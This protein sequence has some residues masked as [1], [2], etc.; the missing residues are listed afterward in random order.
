MVASL[1]GGHIIDSLGSKIDDLWMLLEKAEI[2]NRTENDTSASVVSNDTD[3]IR[4]TRALRKSAIE[5]ID[6]TLPERAPPKYSQNAPDSQRNIPSSSNVSSTT[7]YYQEDADSDDEL[8]EEFALELIAKGIS[9]CREKNY[10]A[11]EP[12]LRNS[13]KTV[14]QIIP[15][16]VSIESIKEAQLEL[17]IAYLY[18]HKFDDAEEILAYLTTD[19]PLSE[20]DAIRKLDAAFYLAQVHL[21]HYSFDEALGSCQ[22][23]V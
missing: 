2:T 20:A 18:Q 22:R 19:S 15:D 16:A 9:L 14:Q 5:V 21:A 6:R 4:H 11:A 10:A 23:A 1:S 13:L 7:A 3:F 12:T 17:A 8:E